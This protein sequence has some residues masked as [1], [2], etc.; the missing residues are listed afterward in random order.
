MGKK[1]PAKKTAK[2]RDREPVTIFCSLT[3]RVNTLSTECDWTGLSVQQLVLHLKSKHRTEI[4]SL[5]QEY[6]TIQGLVRCPKSSAGCEYLGAKG[7]LAKHTS[8]CPFMKPNDNATNIIDDQLLRSNPALLSPSPSLSSSSSSSSSFASSSSSAHFSHSSSFALAKTFLSSIPLVSPASPSDSPLYKRPRQGASPPHPLSRVTSPSIQAITAEERA[9]QLQQSPPAPNTSRRPSST[10]RRS[11]TRWSPFQDLEAPPSSIQYGPVGGGNASYT[12]PKQGSS[13]PLSPFVPAPSPVARSPAGCRPSAQSSA[14]SVTDRS[15]LS[16][17]PG[18]RSPGAPSTVTPSASAAL[19]TLSPRHQQSSLRATA[20]SFSP[21]PVAESRPRASLLAAALLSS[22]AAAPARAPTASPRSESKSEASPFSGPEA[23]AELF[24]CFAP[25]PP[26]SRAPAPSP[27]PSPGPS[28]LHPVVDASDQGRQLRVFSVPALYHTSPYRLS[29]VPTSVEPE[30][31]QCMLPFGQNILLS[32]DQPE[33]QDQAVSQFLIALPT[34][35]ES[36][37]GGARGDKALKQRLANIFAGSEKI[38]LSPVPS[39]VSSPPEPSSTSSSSSGS[40]T[41]QPA[42]SSLDSASSAPD[43]AFPSLV[44]PV[45]SEQQLDGGPEAD[46]ALHRANERMAHKV[47]E[48]MER[49][50]AGA[51]YKAL[52][53]RSPLSAITPGVLSQL[54]TMH[55][56]PIPLAPL[57][58]PPNSPPVL[59]SQDIVLQA[60]VKAANGAAPGPSFCSVDALQTLCKHQTL[61]QAITHV[62][63]SMLNDKMGP[64]SSSLLLARRCIP[65]SKKDGGVR[66]IGIGESFLKVAGTAALLMIPPAAKSELL[67]SFQFAYGRPGAAES[68]VHAIRSHLAS[69]PLS[70]A[71]ALDIRNAYA[72]R[73]REAMLNEMTSDRRSAPLWPLFCFAHRAP[74][75]LLVYKDG[76]LFDVISQLQGVCQGDPPS[77]FAFCRSITRVVLA[78]QARHPNAKIVADADDLSIVGDPEAAFAFFCDLKEELDKEGIVLNLPKSFALWPRPSPPPAVLSS[79]CAKH[80]IPLKVIGASLLGAYVGD[81]DA[82][83]Q[84]HLLSKAKPIV[85]VLAR[86]N[87][88]KIQAQ[89]AA[90]ILRSCIIPA[91]NYSLRTSFPSASASTYAKIDATIADF[92]GSKF[93]LPSSLSDSCINQIHQPIRAGGLGFSSVASIAPAAFTSSFALFASTLAAPLVLPAEAASCRVYQELQ[94]SLDSLFASIPEERLSL[95]IPR[96]SAEL[97]AADSKVNPIKLQSKITTLLASVRNKKLVREAGAPRHQ[98]RLIAASAPSAGL[99]L[100]VLPTEE[101]LRMSTLNFCLAVRLRLG[102][103]PSDGPLVGTTCACGKKIE[104]DDHW[105]GCMLQAKTSANDR[106]DHLK[107][108]VRS[109]VQSAGCFHAA[110]PSVSLTD[111]RRADIICTLDTSS[112]PIAI[113]VSCIHPS[114]KSNELI[115][116]KSLWGAALKREK[117]KLQYYADLTSFEW[118]PFVVESFGAVSPSAH[119]LLD[120]LA[121]RSVSFYRIFPLSFSPRYVKARLLSSWRSM[122]SVAIQQGNAFMLQSGARSCKTAL[123]LRGQP[124]S[125]NGKSC[126]LRIASPGVSAILPTTLM[127]AY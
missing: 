13:V 53:A 22:P 5:D 121:E 89:H 11:P 34:I 77:T 31:I 98:A 59:V 81:D 115:A 95:L 40:S 84:A 97:L 28:A 100:S 92:V 25:R 99:F 73:S 72:E 12:P 54:H 15:L 49:G 71:I 10:S 112:K 9:A 58:L 79:L 61:A 101:A 114:C 37:R 124:F 87:Q 4:K 105:L 76:A 116:M 80:S 30:F 83:I 111:S 126:F 117:E 104:R 48:L 52:H 57:A 17:I 103:P 108:L 67:G 65:T 46:S 33:L 1:S 70:I 125:F 14:L 47:S 127:H 93:L 123:V 36:S 44:F 90:I 18:T 64:I 50:H 69:S 60:I 122:I 26:A 63:S 107:N 39:F 43:V 51:A 62:I 6:L 94:K 38:N 110:E 118:L 120:A 82:G 8:R 21:R 85:D 42:T 24:D 88:P 41:A 23:V 32:V 109:C 102:L 19:V 91:F 68:A 45:A 78:V 55:N 2:K 86:L 29:S 74:T 96:S 20:P 3:Q 56:S 16:P 27:L 66:P 35:L 7:Q 106:H 113:D 119:K 75:P